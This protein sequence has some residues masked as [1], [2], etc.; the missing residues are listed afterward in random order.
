VKGLINI[1]EEPGRPA[2]IQGVQHLLHTMSWLDRWPDADH[3]TQIVFITQGMPR[4][5]LKDVVDLLDRVSARTF[6]AR[7]KGRRLREASTPT[8]L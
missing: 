4:S 7:D 2:V 8:A 5:D 6:K 1:A 3:R